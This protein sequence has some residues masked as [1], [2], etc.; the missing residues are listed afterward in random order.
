MAAASENWGHGWKEF[1]D[2]CIRLDTIPEFYRQTDRQTDRSAVTIS[3]STCIG[4]LTRDKLK[5]TQVE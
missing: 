4:M 3:R 5:I 2:M 1:E